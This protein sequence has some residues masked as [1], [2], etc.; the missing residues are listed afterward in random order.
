[1][2]LSRKLTGAFVVLSLLIVSAVG[3]LAF[4]TSR[5]ALDVNIRNYIASI[6]LLKEGQFNN[7][8]DANRQ[9]LG[10]I[11][12]RPLLYEL[13]FVLATGTNNTEDYKT[14]YDDIY[15]EHLRLLVQDSLGFTELFIL[16]PDTGQILV[17]SDETQVG[18]YR[19]DQL[20]FEEGQ[21]G[22]YVQNPYYSLTRQEQ[23]ITIATPLIGNNSTI[24]G[25]LA[26]HLDLDIASEIMLEGFLNHETGDTFLINQFNFYVTRSRFSDPLEASP[27]IH[28][29]GVENCLAQQTD[30]DTYVNH[31]GVQVI[32][33]YRWIDARELC[34]LTEIH[35]AE[36][37]APIVDLRNATLGVS[38]VVIL[39]GIGMGVGF[40]RTITQP[41]HELVEGTKI[42]GSG[43]LNHR[44]GTL[45][46]DEIGELSRAFDDMVG[47]LQL[48]MASRDDLNAEIERREALEQTLRER[49]TTLSLSLKAAGAGVW[50]W[51]VASGRITWDAVMEEI[52]G[53]EIGTFGSNYDTWKA[54]VH[55]ED[56]DTAENAIRQ[57][58]AGI[59]PFDTTFRVVRPDGAVRYVQAQAVVVRNEDHEPTA[60]IG[61][62]I[63]VTERKQAEQALEKM[64]YD[65]I[66]R[67]KELRGLQDIGQYE[68][69][70]LSL[71]TYFKKV[72]DRVPASM[73][74]PDTCKVAI[75][76]EGQVF[77]D[78]T[79]MEA[80]CNIVNDIR[81]DSHTSGCLYVA[82]D[83][84]RGFLDEEYNHVHAIAERMGHYVSRR[85]L[86][87]ELQ[88]T[89]NNLAKSNQELEQFAYVASHDLQ[90]PLRM[91]TN[92]LQLFKKRYE[93][94]VDERADQYI[95][96]AVDGAN[97]MKTLINDLLS[98]SR[99][100]TRGAEFEE[101]NMNEIL[102]TVL[103]S[104]EVLAQ[105]SDATITS[106]PLPIIS[107]D[108]S[109]MFQLLQN[110]VGNA[111]KFRGQ[112][113]PLIHIGATRRED[114]WEIC[115]E[116]NGIGIA[117]E[118]YD[119][120]FVIFKRLHT[121]EQYKGTGIGLAVCK[122]IVE[123]HGGEIWIES[124]PGI[125][126]KFKFTVPIMEVEGDRYAD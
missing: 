2:K 67:V 62:N 94:Q 37:F 68:E 69:E 114:A 111:I 24:A 76:F 64:S 29:Q 56:I 82:Y 33:A 106:D 112:T 1:M 31:A 116:D 30:T 7:W 77:G 10:R 23:I 95:F 51:D 80:N 11:A 96:Y 70:V 5:R 66:E 21:N 46:R 104:L 63:D 34:I 6:S 26:G 17:S 115:V 74:F 40:S 72:I 86:F 36:A 25:V 43:K 52:H 49:E 79:A 91:V 126:S 3:L 48:V 35:E 97:R 54:S 20:F 50:S 9:A 19:E 60:M 61:V 16:H 100:T 73:Q 87:D 113:P 75:E 122:R 38:S 59:K 120:I 108:G 42:I 90:E 83:Q 65:L 58:I 103:K 28:S 45:A 121:R 124:Q 118:Y 15:N 102:G 32:G 13:A 39:L 109:Q 55:P 117:P 12:K 98:F 8:V 4:E 93:G 44:V 84:D 89:L 101:T 107:A 88:R 22:T 81:V 47:N 71:D 125:G 14:A 92:Y 119:Q 99:V 18:K 110:L 41:I 57:A 123:R 85:R 78:V 105:E 27:A 53:L